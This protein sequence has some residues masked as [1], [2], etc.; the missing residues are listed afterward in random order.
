[1]IARRYSGKKQ[2]FDLEKL[3]QSHL[4]EGDKGSAHQTVQ[5]PKEAWLSKVV[6]GQAFQVQV[7]HASPGSPV[8]EAGESSGRSLPNLADTRLTMRHSSLST[9]DCRSSRYF[10][11]Q[12][13]LSISPLSYILKG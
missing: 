10:A 9:L 7:V 5:Q 3:S 13:D 6:S 11:T 12:I 2:R 1:M 4:Q 8:S